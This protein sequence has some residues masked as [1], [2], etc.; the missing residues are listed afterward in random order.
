MKAAIFSALLLALAGVLPETG[1]AQ[2]F[3]ST[4]GDVLEVKNDAG[5]L[6]VRWDESGLT[7][8]VNYSISGTAGAV[9][10]CVQSGIECD[11]AQSISVSFGPLSPDDGSI[12]QTAALEEPPPPTSCGCAGGDQLVLY[13]VEYRD[14]EICDDQHGDCAP[15]ASYSTSLCKAGS[16]QNCPLAS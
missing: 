16:L 10:A 6:I 11:S 14:I 8:P 4:Y 12:R 2:T 9:Y 1:F 7:G 5:D 13:H 15:V 3:T